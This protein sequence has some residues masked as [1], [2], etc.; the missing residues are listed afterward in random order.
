MS[1]LIKQEKPK[2]IFL[3]EL[4]LAYSEQKVLK[5]DFPDYDFHVSTPDM[6]E[7]C[8]NIIL[9]TGPAW[10][11]TAVAWHRDLQPCVTQLPVTH[12]R[13]TAIK[14]SFSSIFTMLAISLYSPTAGKDDEF[15]ECVDYLFEF[16]SSNSWCSAIVV[17]T[18]SNCSPKSS[19]RRRNAW[20]NLCSNFNLKVQSTNIPTFHHN[21]G[22]SESCIDYFLTTN[23][24]M[25][26]L[27][28]LCTLD[29]PTNLSSHDPILST[30]QAQ[31]SVSTAPSLYSATYTTYLPRKVVWNASR[32]STYQELSDNALSK[33]CNFWNS[34]EFIP[35]L[36]TLLPKL[37]VQSAELAME[38]RSPD[39]ATKGYRKS[40]KIDNLERRLDKAFRKWNSR[41]RQKSKVDP[42]HLS[43]LKAKSDFQQARRRHDYLKNVKINNDLMSSYKYNRNNIYSRMKKLRGQQCFS[44]PVCL[45]TPVGNYSGNDVLEGFAADA[46]YLARHRGEPE[47]YDNDFYRLCKLDN[48]FIF[49]FK[50]EEEIKI[51]T[52]SRARFEEIINSEMKRGKACDIYHL[53]VEH[54][55]FCGD[56]AKTCIL[57]LLNSIISNIYYLSCSQS[58]AGVGS[59]IHKS[60]G[61]P[62]NKSKSYRR[63][64]VSPQLGTILDR[65]IDPITENIFRS[66]QSP[67][68]LGFTRG[69]SYLLAAVQRGEC[70]RWAVDHK[71]TCFGVSLDGEAAF[72]SVDR[73]I[74]V[75]ELYSTGERGDILKYS[76][77]TYI[78]TECAIKQDGKLSRTFTEY[79]GNRQGHVKA[80]GHFKAYINPCLEA[81]SSA[82]LGFQIGQFIVGAEC[83]ADD[84]YIQTDTKSGLQAAIDL[85]CH[86]ARRYR[87]TFNADKTKIVVTGSK[88]DMDYY[89]QIKPWT[90]NGEKIEVVDTNEHLGLLVS[91][92][93]EEQKNVDNNISSCRNSL[94]SLLG[95][96][97]SYKCKLS[98]VVQIHL[99]RTYSL[100]VLLSGLAALPVRPADIRSMRIFHNKILRGFL[101]LSMTSAVSGLYFLCGELPIEARI[102]IDLLTLFH[103]I[104]SN[105]ETKVFNLV[106]YLM[107]MSRDNSTTWSNH[108]R[109]ICKLYDLP[110]PLA[111]LHQSP[112]TKQSWKT[113]VHTKI[114]VFHETQLK[115]AAAK[116][117]NME[118]FNVQ[119]LGLSGVP[120]PALRD[121]TDSRE[122][123]KLK[124]HLKFLIGDVLSYAKLS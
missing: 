1:S 28:Q 95:S 48:A 92:I 118:Y 74:Q 78:N 110:D 14:I 89:Q 116:N 70:Q 20:L 115:G 51:P 121:I 16:L 21:N 98:P 8:E 114:L 34:P 71:L 75:R 44:A 35:F 54:I 83:C 56:K 32:L 104:W 30:I 23:C 84:L 99:W 9:H 69:I 5:Q 33:A 47:V 96:A 63:I 39:P 53:T 4:W 81:I 73:D 66:V 3:Q 19:K 60:K 64:T 97:L 43:Y 119:L 103:N 107:K 59:C 101:K 123:H 68:Q 41:G 46:E 15:L 6:L 62:R 122:A 40:A 10:H 18:D 42:F 117:Q 111:L 105:R 113:L 12:D 90:L 45:E 76:K 94:F 31:V 102:H 88:L 109:L 52:M 11:G 37:L 57:N 27:R 93:K 17:G 72:P 91:G 38:T 100:P 112:M 29:S 58:K 24:P 22:T 85:V 7:H 79:T 50:G 13:F 49:E 36:C 2:I 67:D 26:D 87:V 77:N 108:V 80:S 86:Y 61:K 55:Q 124:A 120:H 25:K 106:V 65:Y 82:G